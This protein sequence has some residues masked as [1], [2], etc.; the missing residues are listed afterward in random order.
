MF[1]ELKKGFM[2]GIG[3]LLALS[4]ILVYVGNAFATD[5]SIPATTV[6]LTNNDSKTITV[7]G[8]G[9]AYASPD[10]A[11]ITIGVTTNAATSTS[12]LSQN[13][14]QMNAVV[15]AI[16]A[17]GIPAKDI[18]TSWV[19][20]SPVYNYNLATPKITGYSASNTV[21]VTVR[22]TSKLGPVIDAANNAGANQINGVS[23]S[24]SDNSSSAVYQQ[25]LTGAIA[26]GASKAKAIAIAAGIANPQ[27]KSVTESGTSYVYT[28]TP[29]FA[30]G[31]VAGNAASTPV[32]TGQQ[33]VQA[34]V[35]MVYTFA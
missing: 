2:F 22:D 31:V 11:T 34:A 15:A 17:A 10:I 16:K 32:S 21:T 19:S 8:N 24:L 30:S 7:T 29:A 23:F 14:N 13:S 33:R 12:A 20:V 26:D 1:M 27:L 5:T 28:P 18:Q 6:V 9:Y 4:L 35:T 3:V 25:A